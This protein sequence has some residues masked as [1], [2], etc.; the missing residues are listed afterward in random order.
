M[1][2]VPDPR[3]HGVYGYAEVIETVRWGLSE[4]GHEVSVAVNT[5]ANDRT[6]IIFGAQM[7][8][9][10]TLQRLPRGSIVYHLEQMAGIPLAELRPSIP[11]IAQNFQIWEY[12]QSNQEAWRRVHDACQPKFVPI[13]WAPTLRRI[14][15]R[16]DEDIDVLFYGLPNE[17]RLGALAGLCV[18]GLKCVYAC[19]LYGASRD[20]LI[21][22]AKLVLNLNLY[23]KTRLFEIVRVSYLLANGK[24]VVSDIFPDSVV[25]PDIKDAVA[26]TPPEL[27]TETCVKL[28]SDNA[29]RSTLASRGQAIIE[30]RDIRQILS[31]ALDG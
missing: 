8:D 3:I 5:Y 21:G 25:E 16:P 10:P 11:Y 29:A 27:L 24:A 26:F 12:S 2:V 17:S 20:D 14:P 1:H 22:R 6:N 7:I 30:R 28:I 31:K 15:K 19:G 4:L 13:G 18:V 23:K 9:L